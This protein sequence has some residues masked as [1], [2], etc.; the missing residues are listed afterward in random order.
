MVWGIL[1]VNQNSSCERN[2]MSGLPQPEPPAAT[3]A[4]PT[5]DTAG[6]PV[7][8]T[9]AQE[10]ARL[11]ANAAASLAPAPP[12]G[13]VAALSSM[14][15]NLFVAERTRNNDV[16]AQQAREYERQ[17]MMQ[18]DLTV[19]RESQLSRASSIGTGATHTKVI[20]AQLD[21][22]E[23]NLFHLNLAI[24]ELAK[25]LVD[26]PVQPGSPS[27]ASPSATVKTWFESEDGALVCETVSS[28]L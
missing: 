9:E 23:T 24:A 18:S 4:A 8:E 12:E 13:Q 22:A 21:A 14:V 2:T 6:G 19:L 15:Q 25:R 27:P 17:L 1:S 5:T 10:L 7:P 16:H 20:A 26:V 11:R 28:R 3:D